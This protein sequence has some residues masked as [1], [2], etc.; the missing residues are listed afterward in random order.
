MARPRKAFGE[1]N[2]NKSCLLICT[3]HDMPKIKISAHMACR[4]LRLHKIIQKERRSGNHQTSCY[5]YPKQANVY[6]SR[7]TDRCFKQLSGT[8]CNFTI[9]FKRLYCGT[10]PINLLVNFQPCWVTFLYLVT[11]ATEG[12]CFWLLQ[13]LPSLFPVLNILLM[14]HWFQLWS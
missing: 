8:S 3:F 5:S 12:S 14:M 1:C 6:R 11:R 10:S 7:C 2:D 9:E 4:N 13:K